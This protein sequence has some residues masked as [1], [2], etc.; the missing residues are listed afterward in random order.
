MRLFKTSHR[1][2]LF[3]LI[4][5]LAGLAGACSTDPVANLNQVKPGNDP[6]SMDELF[7]GVMYLTRF[8]YGTR[9]Q[10]LESFARNAATFTTTDSRFITMWLGNGT[11]ISSSTFY[12]TANWANN[13]TAIRQAQQL[14]G[15][16]P[17][18]VPAYSAGDLAKWKG[19]IYTIEALDYMQAEVTK[20]TLGT[21]V[22][23]PLGDVNKPQPILCSRDTWKFIVAL[24]DSGLTQLN[25]D[26]SAGLP[27]NFP[28]G[29]AAV[30]AKASPSTSIGAFAAFNRALAVK[31]NL[32]LAYAFARSPGGNPPT[33]AGPG[34]PNVA[35][36]TSADSALHA[37]ALWDTTALGPA[38]AGADFTDPLAVYM[39]FSGSSGDIANAVQ[40]ALP[41]IY[42][43]NE[44]LA[45]IDPADHRLSKLIPAAQGAK[46]AYA[47]KA[48]G[49]TFGMYQTPN[50]PIPVIRNEEL[51][52][53]LA[54]IRLGLGDIA[55]AV[56]AINVV[57]SKVGG[58]PPI[59]PATYTAV[60]DAILKELRASTLGEAGGDR[61]SAIR[62][63]GLPV[64]ADTTWAGK[65]LHT[66]VEP[67]PVPDVTTR[68]GNTH[69]TCP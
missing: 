26:P 9:V 19:V 66:T 41:T 11:P 33:T 62:D 49:F 55:G 42:V 18:T 68:N 37:T 1:V 23:G 69:Y 12:G 4:A 3:G 53:F 39:N 47:A 45:D 65:D 36:L 30:S 43:L 14:L 13:F 5:T 51:T 21:P 10:M 67:F 60:R 31:A 17:T 54:Q 58:L 15:V 8:D 34:S 24:L 6:T 57:R 46:T 56:R 59:A 52:L 22:Q 44:A 29:F 61:T 2:A 64:V 25:A 27:M 32:E 40:A 35:A 7:Q 48:S 20:D 50:S 38:T 16:L 28:S 63:Y